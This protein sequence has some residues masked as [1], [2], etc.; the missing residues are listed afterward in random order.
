MDETLFCPFTRQPCM[1]RDCAC[2]VYT[3]RGAIAYGLTR[4]WWCGLVPYYEGRQS[5]IYEE[6][7]DEE[8]NDNRKD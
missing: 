7:M 8:P 5:P 6:P 1:G 2:A 3:I 4:R